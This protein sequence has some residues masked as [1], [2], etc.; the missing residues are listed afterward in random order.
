MAASSKGHGAFYPGGGGPHRT[1]HCHATHL[2]SDARSGPR[3]VWALSAGG[4][5]A[6]RVPLPPPLPVC[7]TSAPSCLGAS[8]PSKPVY[9]SEQPAG[10]VPPSSDLSPCTNV[11]PWA[12][13]V[14]EGFARRKPSNGVTQ[15]SPTQT[16]GCARGRSPRKSSE[17]LARE[18]SRRLLSRRCHVMW[19]PRPAARSMVSGCPSAR[20][21]SV[22]SSPWLP[23]KIHND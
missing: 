13:V 4:H 9:V 17:G 15:P 23:H 14:Q 10:G 1:P 8:I 11:L 12:G 16:P 2:L 21:A 5:S 3:I 20:G 7:C 18:G 6:Q 19:P 22:S